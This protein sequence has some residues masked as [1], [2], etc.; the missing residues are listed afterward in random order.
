MTYGEHDL[1]PASRAAELWSS[2]EPP[3]D[4]QIPVLAVDGGL[5]SKR[6]DRR[7]RFLVLFAEAKGAPRTNIWVEIADLTGAPIAAVQSI[8]PWLYVDILPGTYTLKA[9]PRDG[10]VKTLSFSA[11]PGKPKVLRMTWWSREARSVLAETL[12]GSEFERLQ[13]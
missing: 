8:K 2:L 13:V 10:P 9:T 6:T 7:S 11:A 3:A 1:P 4:G 12:F 5:A